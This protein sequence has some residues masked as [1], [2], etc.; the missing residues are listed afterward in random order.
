MSLMR[1]FCSLMP[2]CRSEAPEPGEPR[3]PRA[4]AKAAETPDV[5]AFGA[6]APKRPPVLDGPE[7]HFGR[8]RPS[9]PH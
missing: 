2:G 7:N 6:A 3:E 8:G 9:R 5:E 4:S 1:F